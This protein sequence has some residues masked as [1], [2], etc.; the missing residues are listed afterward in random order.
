MG[1]RLELI[2]ATALAAAV[3]CGGTPARTAPA[4]P[5]D[6]G[7]GAGGDEITTVD[8]ETAAQAAIG[9]KVKISGIAQNAKLGA[10]VEGGIV[11]YCRGQDEWPADVAGTQ[12]TVI[13]TLELTDAYAAT[14]NEAGEISAGTAGHDWILHDCVPASAAP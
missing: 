5:Q 9:K 1:A 12:V 3:A 4:P 14:V 10:I 11:V 6:P 7:A 2:L 13:G 8:G